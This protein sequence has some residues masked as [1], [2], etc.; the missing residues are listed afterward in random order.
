MTTPLC[1]FCLP[2]QVEAHWCA[3]WSHGFPTYS[4][5]LPKETLWKEKPKGEMGA[6]YCDEHYRHFS[7]L[8]RPVIG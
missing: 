6:F 8:F 7:T 5:V 3:T 1:D 2:K 4:N